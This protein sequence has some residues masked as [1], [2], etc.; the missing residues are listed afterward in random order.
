LRL[1]RGKDNS[2]TGELLVGQIR[3]NWPLSLRGCGPVHRWSGTGADGRA[4]EASNWKVWQPENNGGRIT[5]LERRMEQHEQDWQRA[6]GFLAA[7]SVLF[8]LIEVAVEAWR[9][10]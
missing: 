5:D 1:G 7:L 6:K 3:C 4:K 9:H 2:A 10:H 8:A